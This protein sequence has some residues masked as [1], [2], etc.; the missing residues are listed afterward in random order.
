[1]LELVIDNTYT[2]NKIIEIIQGEEGYGAEYF[3]EGS[4]QD[5]YGTI[6]DHDSYIFLMERFDNIS[7]SIHILY[8]FDGYD[9]IKKNRETFNNI[10]TIFEE[11]DE[12]E[13]QRELEYI[14][15]QEEKNKND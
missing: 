2:R 12:L 4:L 13:Y 9:D 1:M 7:S 11:Y 5:S 8:V 14:K 10:M 6:F 3:A 15:E